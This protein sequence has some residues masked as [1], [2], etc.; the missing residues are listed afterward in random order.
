MGKI[1]ALFLAVSLSMTRSV[2]AQMD[3]DRQLGAAVQ[4]ASQ[5]HF[6]D[7]RD[8]ARS[9]V[10][11]KE[12]NDME[13][14]RAWTILGSIYQYHGEFQ[15]A[16]TSYEKALSILKERDEYASDY[17]ATLATTATLFLDMRQV[18]LAAQVEIRA[19]QVDKRSLNHSAIA[20]DCVS[21]A[22]IE[23]GRKHSR[24]AQVWLDQ[25][26]QEAKSAPHL[27]SSFY[28]MLASSQAWLEELTGDASAAIAGYQND[29]SY[30]VE[31]HGTQSLSVGW[32]YILLGKA[33]LKN[34]EITDALSSIRTG[35][36]LLRATVGTA[37]PRYL[38]AQI[39][40]SEALKSAG[41]R[42]EAVRVR[43][44]AERELKTFYGN[45]CA[46]CRTTAVVSH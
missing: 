20:A 4:L 39:A 1:S 12:L 16:M 25:A 8:L 31:L 10:R 13:R 5:G 11:S 29:I 41:Q 40:Y 34:A 23:L 28:A 24:K 3:T 26:V 6:E 22:N 15:E 35:C 43:Q 38:L 36:A 32:A 9:V 18:D 7:A 46:Q 19:L 2:A 33:Y 27:D 42:A 21:L 30:L 44:E 17:S 37:H 14:G 45:Q